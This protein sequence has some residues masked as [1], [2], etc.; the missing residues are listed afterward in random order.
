[1]VASA[2]AFAQGKQDFILVNKTGYDISE[3]YVSAS[4]TNDWEEDVL[5]SQT[6]EDG[7]NLTVNFKN[8][9]KSCKFDLKVV[10]EEDD[11]SAYWRDIDLCKVSKVTIF[12]SAKADETRADFE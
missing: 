2:T 1:M 4:K 5:G 7:E 6:L 11:S 9:G 10:Y 12:Y 8:A 3:V